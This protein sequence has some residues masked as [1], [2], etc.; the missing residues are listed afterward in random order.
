VKEKEAQKL[1]E[2]RIDLETERENYKDLHRQMLELTRDKVR[3]EVTLCFL[4]FF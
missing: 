1:N 4:S 3:D 2:V